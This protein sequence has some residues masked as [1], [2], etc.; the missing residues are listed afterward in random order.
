MNSDVLIVGAGPTGLA[1][2]LFLA[3]RGV[4][5]RIIDKAAAPATASRAQLVNPRALELLDGIGCAAEIVA[6]ARPL[7][8]VVFHHQWERVGALD[9]DEI[10]PKFKMSVLPQARTEAILTA[11]L[12]A[13]GIVPERRL[14]FEKF[15]Q[16]PEGVDLIL[17]HPDKQRDAVRTALLF[18]ADG[19]NSPV[20][21]AMGVAFIGSDFPEEWP[22]YDIHLANCPLDP[23]EV[24]I[25]FVDG[26]LVVLMC[27]RDGVWRLF[28]DVPGL[29]GHLPPGTRAGE[30]VWQSAF[31][32]A[33][34]LAE[35]EVDGRV[36]IGGDA[37][38]I[39]SPVAARGMNLGIEDAY[40]YAACAADVLKGASERLSDY[41]RLRQ[42]A[43]RQVVSEVERLTQL[44]RG[45]P[46]V[47]GIFRQMF[48]PFM[49]AFPPVARAVKNLVTGL[50]HDVDLG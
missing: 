14:E 31:H 19:A 38:H 7:S 44:A 20:R 40:V 17:R 28:G 1:A 49:T 22:L 27:I 2:G 15:A 8:G 12:A 48:V 41:G 35:R 6:E 24:H 43:H 16:D 26:G 4:S 5:C 18:G 30:A 10:H 39:H 29:L 33:H 21:K 11:A 46:S 32:I 25:C 45:R 23:A 34:R 50:D 13:K 9:F 37:A 42:V 36:A 3:D 47:I